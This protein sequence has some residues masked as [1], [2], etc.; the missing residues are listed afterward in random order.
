MRAEHLV[1]FGFMGAALAQVVLGIERPRVGLLSIGE[2]ASKGT[3]LVIEAHAA[4]RDRLAEGDTFD[5]VGNVEGNEVPAGKADVVVTDGFT[6]NVAL[7]LME[8]VSEEML[9]QIRDV[10]DL[11]AP[12]QGRRHAAAPGAARVPRGHRPRERRRRLPAGPAPA[13]R[14]AP[15]ALQPPRHRPGDPA[16]GR[17][18]VEGDVVGRT[19]AALEAAHAL[20]PARLSGSPSTVASP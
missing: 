20:R 6:G 15:R 4:L 17:A 3:P 16:R 7:K 9:R 2:E 1:Q 10:A 12:R 19:H 8:G 5:F 13:R 14:G 18:A 11:V